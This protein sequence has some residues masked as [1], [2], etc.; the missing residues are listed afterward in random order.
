ME[1][2]ENAWMNDNDTEILDHD[3]EVDH[4]K[5]IAVSAKLKATLVS[6]VC[7][8]STVHWCVC[9]NSARVYLHQQCMGVPA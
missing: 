6:H 8:G 1:S 3:E 5:R 7:F 9:I 4:P 2:M